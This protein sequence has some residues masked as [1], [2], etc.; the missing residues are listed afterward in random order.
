MS[1]IRKSQVQNMEQ[2]IIIIHVG[3]TLF[4][5]NHSS[6]MHQILKMNTNRV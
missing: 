6:G 3:I 5:P 4:S 1:G 2:N